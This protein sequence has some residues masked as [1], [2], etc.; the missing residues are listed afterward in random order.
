M[1]TNIKVFVGLVSIVLLLGCSTYQ[2]VRLASTTQQNDQSAFVIENDSLNI[3]YSFY[4]QGGPIY[5]E[6][7]NKLDKPF[8]I[9]WRKSALIING[10]SFSLWKDE[11]RISGTT[12]EYRIIPERNIAYSTG[13]LEGTIA[14]ADK[15]TFIPPH[16]KIIVNSYNLHNQFFNAP[17]QTGKKMK[18]NTAEGKREAMKFSFTKEDSPLNF[19]IFLSLSM[20]ESFK[21][22]FQFDN[23]FWVS[24]YF[25]TSASPGALGTYPGNQFYNVK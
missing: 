24:D 16:S 25:T 17:E 5:M 20:D 18:L 6:L 3:I 8:Y 10:Q 22:P 13:N 23:S 12:T 2:H 14:R 1:K 4:G 15:V 21:K 7:L 11:A 9:D 19:R